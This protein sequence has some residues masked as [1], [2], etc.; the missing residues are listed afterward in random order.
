M[1]A[2]TLVLSKQAKIFSLITNIS[3]RAMIENGRRQAAI[4]LQILETL[5]K[6]ITPLW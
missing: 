4:P 1:S 2:L 5:M 3:L 6:A